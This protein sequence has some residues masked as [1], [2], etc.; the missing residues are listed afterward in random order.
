MARTPNPPTCTENFAPHANGAALPKPELSRQSKAS[1]KLLLSWDDL[2]EWRQDNHYIRSHYRVTTYSY[3]GSF[4]SLFYLHNESVNIHTHLFAALFFLV[5]A[6][7]FHP[8]ISAY[9][10]LPTPGS[11]SLLSQLVP[12]DILAFTFFFAGAIACLGISATYHTISNHSPLVNQWGNQ[13][14]YVGIVALITGSFIPS[15]YYGFCGRQEL[16]WVYWGM[17]SCVVL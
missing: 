12:A 8:T 7:Y 15:V 5:L 9:L 17:V 3:I 11:T 13:L 4:K 10:L 2:P 14:D 6:V 1:T 16:Q